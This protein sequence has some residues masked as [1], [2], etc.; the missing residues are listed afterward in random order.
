M[1]GLACGMLLKEIGVIDRVSFAYPRDIETG[2]IEI[3]AANI[4][5]GLPYRKEAHLA[6]DHYPGTSADSDIRGNLITDKRMPSTSR[7]IYNHY[8]RDKFSRISP[9]MLDAV[10]KGYSAKITSDEI[11]YPGGWIL[12]GY[13]IDQRTGLERFGRFSMSNEEIVAMLVDG[14]RERTIWEILS[15]PA[16]EERL[17]VYFSNV[18][19]YKGQILRCASVYYN[20]V[21]FD[22]RM[23]SKIFPGNRFMVYALF[24]ECNVSLQVISDP[25]NDKVVFV[26]G[27]SVL[28][29]S[30]SGDIGSIM[31]KY[32]GGGH[33]AAGT[34]QT[35][36]D[37][38]DG[39]LENLINEL[40]YSTLRNLVEG[41]FNYYYHD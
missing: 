28:D 36:K 8:G 14:Y 2:K 19:Q 9:D 29:R 39:V 30:Y 24:P 27:K 32:G 13:L 31:R 3:N 22:M 26:A 7:V 34:C 41:Y 21:V 37:K 12:F 40:Q 6:F 17:A 11:L 33:S 1:D 10:D 15:L 38:A 25:K 16:M 18:D 35:E 20:L 23:E 4:T 5:A